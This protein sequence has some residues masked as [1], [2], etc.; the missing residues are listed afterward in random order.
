MFIRIVI[1]KVATGLTRV[2]PR[3]LISPTHLEVERLL[4]QRMRVAARGELPVLERL[5]DTA[6]E[7]KHRGEQTHTAVRASI[8]GPHLSR[9]R[10]QRLV[11]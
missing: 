6:L 8:P 9:D 3:P 10:L 1:L 5:V 2:S 11:T 7:Q 4:S